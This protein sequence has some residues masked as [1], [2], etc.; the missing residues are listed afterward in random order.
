MIRLLFVPSIEERSG[1]D[2]LLPDDPKNLLTNTMKIPVI[3]GINE[4]EGLIMVFG[5]KLRIIFDAHL[6]CEAAVLGILTVF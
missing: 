2:V 1:S 4:L 3:T 6:E 5:K